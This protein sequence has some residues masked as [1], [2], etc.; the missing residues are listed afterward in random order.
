MSYPSFCAYVGKSSWPELVGKNGCFAA[1]TIK[2]ENPFVNT[3]ILLE[4]SP[5]TGDFRCDR[6]RVVVDK[7]NIVVQVPVIT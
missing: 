1:E 2:K 3:V 6:V 5:V 4:G 7:N